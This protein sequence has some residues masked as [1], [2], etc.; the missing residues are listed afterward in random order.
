MGRDSLSRFPVAM[1]QSAMPAC[2]EVLRCHLQGPDSDSRL[3][4]FLFPTSDAAIAAYVGKAEPLFMVTLALRGRLSGVAEVHR[5][6][7]VSDGVEIAL[8]V[9]RNPRRIGFGGR[10]FSARSRN[11]GAAISGKSGSSTATA[12]NRCTAS[13][14]G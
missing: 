3:D 10:H 1:L 4:R 14:R 7:D 12:T 8:S 5:H 13:R 9:D 2:R 11:A 6:P